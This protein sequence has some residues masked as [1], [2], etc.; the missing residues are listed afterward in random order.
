MITR[1]DIRKTLQYK[2]IKYRFNDKCSKS[3][4][5]QNLSEAGK[6][7]ILI[8]ATKK[9][10]KITWII[11]MVY[12]PIMLYFTFGFV[13]NYRYADNAFVK[14]FT[15][16]YESVFPLINGDW[17]SAWYEKKGTF[18][19]IFIKL[20]PAIIIQAMPIFIP[21][22]IAANKALKDEMKFID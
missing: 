3:E 6:E 10:R 20:I 16:I 17:G 2:Y 1:M 5:L 7:E 11:I 9:T 22:M 15:G 12:I 19:I 8:K 21:V 18:L 14:W 4:V 13:L